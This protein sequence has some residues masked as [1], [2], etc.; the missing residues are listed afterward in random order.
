MSSSSNFD[1]ARMYAGFYSLTHP[2]ISPIHADLKGLPPI[3]IQV[4]FTLP[5]DDQY[6]NMY[7]F[8][9]KV[10]EVEVLHDEATVLARRAREAGVDVT[11]Q[12]YPD[13]VHVFQAFGSLVPQIRY[14]C[15][16]AVLLSSC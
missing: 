5:F 10:G 9:S 4:A 2:L 15:F 11:L 12:V 16:G 6:G 1:C 14:F 3:L 7:I 8:F 13:M